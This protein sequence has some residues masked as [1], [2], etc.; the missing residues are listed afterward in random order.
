MDINKF[1]DKIL[2]EA[3]DLSD[4]FFRSKHINKRNKE[5]IRSREGKMY[6]KLKNGLKKIKIAYKSE[7]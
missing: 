4:D 1:I 3:E 5:F 2:K 6:Y 7:I